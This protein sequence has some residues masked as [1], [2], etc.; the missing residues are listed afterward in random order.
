MSASTVSRSICRA[1]IGAMLM[2]GVASH[3]YA[4][5]WVD[6]SRGDIT[7]EWSGTQVVSLD[8][9]DARE[10]AAFFLSHWLLID[11]AQERARLAQIANGLDPNRDPFDDASRA[12]ISKTADNTEAVFGLSLRESA[13]QLQDLA[14]RCE[15]ETGLW[16]LIVVY[17]ELEAADRH[18]FFT[19]SRF[20]RMMK[21]YRNLTYL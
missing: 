10:Q 1:L 7:V 17:A 9:P 18:G 20:Q 6:S 11:Q 21:S 4:V 8:C 15:N 3:V 19:W 5:E 12:Q 13:L 14:S 16:I 2:F